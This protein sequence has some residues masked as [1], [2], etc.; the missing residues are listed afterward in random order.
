MDFK[1]HLSKK[2]AIIAS[3][4]LVLVILGASLWFQSKANGLVASNLHPDQYAVVGKK[5]NPILSLKNLSK[6]D[7]SNL[8]K[9]NIRVTDVDFAR[10]NRGV[11]LTD[12]KILELAH[13]E[14]IML[15]LLASKIKEH[16]PKS[17]LRMVSHLRDAH[18]QFMAEIARLEEK[19]KKLLIEANPAL[20]EEAKANDLRQALDE[21]L[22]AVEQKFHYI[23]SNF[24]ILHIPEAEIKDIAHRDRTGAA[25]GE[26]SKGQGVEI[27]IGS[28]EDMDYIQK[29]N[30]ANVFTGF[31]NPNDLEKLTKGAVDTQ[32]VIRDKG[33]LKKLLKNDVVMAISNKNPY[34]AVILANVIYTS[35]P[36]KVSDLLGC[37]KVARNRIWDII[38][39]RF[40][41]G[42]D[43]L[44]KANPDLALNTNVL[45][46]REAISNYLEAVQQQVMKFI[47][48]KKKPIHPLLS[49]DQVKEIADKALAKQ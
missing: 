36:Y 49:D 30:L 33:D 35:A 43:R 7:F 19:G 39:N 23:R 28:F 1:Q 22:I 17:Q 29:N 20:K 2:T 11:L 45:K 9:R 14:G 40:E 41:D 10:F 21:Y 12:P 38:G 4:S 8:A 3:V 5:L 16:P 18:R 32:S 24:V 37:I 44:L 48:E 15:Y 42:M 34:A 13:N 25:T 31:E 6:Y 47:E 46:L 27:D 26:S